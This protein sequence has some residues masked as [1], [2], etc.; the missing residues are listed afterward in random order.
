MAELAATKPRAAR[1]RTYFNQ[2]RREVLTGYLFASPW[3]FG[4]LTL[5]LGPMI[6]SLYASFTV[7]DITTL[8][9]VGAQNYQFIFQHDPDFWTALRNT[10]WYVTFKTPAVIIA[11]LALALLMN[12]P[13]PGRKAFRT[14]FYMPTVV[15]GVAAI[16]LWVWILSP[17]GLLNTVL[18]ALHLPQPEWFLDPKYSKPG[19]I[20]MGVWYIGSP[21]LIL[22][23]GLSGIPKH[24]YEAAKIDGAGVLS[25]F[26]HI[27]IPMLSPTLFF[28]ILTNIIGAFQVF[29]SAYVISTSASGAK[30]QIGDPENSLLFYEVYLYNQFKQDLLGYA[31]ALAWILFVVVLAITIVQLWLSRKWVYYE[32]G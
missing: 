4:F 22:L 18:G 6:F 32:G 2:R 7:Y 14:I 16:F 15:T 3:I 13:V 17:L 30:G 27:T 11:S 23:A 31:S 21:M 9:W 29:N 26:R 10:L 12:Q 5:T 19:M 24:L 8:K 28:I 1:P 20:I 25:R